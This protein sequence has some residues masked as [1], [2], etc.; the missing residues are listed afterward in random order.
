[1]AIKNLT[2][3][4]FKKWLRGKTLEFLPHVQGCHF[5]QYVSFLTGES[6]VI[7]G[8]GFISVNGKGNY[9]KTPKWAV[10]SMIKDGA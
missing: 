1:M 3:Y 6:R 4:Q 8:G 5:A 7:P 9:T 2:N 10:R